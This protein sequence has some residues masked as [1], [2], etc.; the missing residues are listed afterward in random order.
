MSIFNDT[1]SVFE[2]LASA[3]MRSLVTEINAHTHDGA[4]GTKILFSNLDGTIGASQI[5]TGLIVA[6][7]IANTTITGGK[8]GAGQITLTHLDGTIHLSG[9]YAVYAP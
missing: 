1:F 5:G 7:M 9:G 4:Y 2:R 6:S 8:I 3:K